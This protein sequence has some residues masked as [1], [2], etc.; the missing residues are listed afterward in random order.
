[1]ICPTCRSTLFEE[2]DQGALVCQLCGTQ[3]QEYIAE[4]FDAEEGMVST[5][6]TGNSKE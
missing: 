1:M 5:V 3:S 6:H 4:S 2:D